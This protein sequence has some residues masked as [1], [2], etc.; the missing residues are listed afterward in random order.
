MG[1]SLYKVDAEF[2]NVFRAARMS[3]RCLLFVSACVAV[4][5]GQGTAFGP[6]EAGA[7]G[8]SLDAVAYNSA[9]KSWEIDV[10]Y[11]LP[12]EDT[13]AV[14]YMPKLS[15]ADFQS[16]FQA[17]MHPCVDTTSVCCLLAFAEH[18]T[19]GTFADTITSTLGACGAD[20]SSQDTAALF[21]AAAYPTVMDNL[22]D[23][24]RNRA[25]S[26][27]VR[28]SPTT[29]QMQVTDR[30][31]SDFF[32]STRTTATGYDLDFFVGVAFFTVLPAPVVSTTTSQIRVNVQYTDSF[33]F[34]SASEQDYSFVDRVTLSIFDNKW[35]SDLFV[36]HHPQAARVGFLLGNGLQQNMRTGLVPA[37]STQFAIAQSQPGPDDPRWVSS[38]GDVLAAQAAVYN[39]SLMEACAVQGDLCANPG[40]AEIPNRYHELWLP[41]GDDAVNRTILDSGAPF[42]LYLRF[43]VSVVDAS[44]A[45]LQTKLFLQSPLSDLAVT[46]LCTELKVAT[47][48]VDVVD[49]HM[50]VGMVGVESEWAPTMGVYEN[51]LVADTAPLVDVNIGSGAR[52]IQNSL[53]TLVLQAEQSMFR[54][55]DRS[56]YLEV[57][58]IVSLHFLDSAV[59]DTVSTMFASGEAWTL[60]KDPASGI[61]QIVLTQELLDLCTAAGLPGDLTCAVRYDVVDHVPVSGYGVH[62]MGTAATHVQT[63]PYSEDATVAWMQ[64]S[65]LGVSEYSDSLA[66][67][68]TALVRDRY[69]I[70]EHYN[71]ALYLNPGFPWTL[72]AGTGQSTLS[73]SDRTIWIIL[74]RL[75]GLS[76]RRR[77]LLQ[78]DSAEEQFYEKIVEL[79]EKPMA[80]R[81][82]PLR[83]YA[84]DPLVQTA[85]A[86]GV[87]RGFGFADVGLSVPVELDAKKLKRRVQGL[88]GESLGVISPT[89]AGAWVVKSRRV[90]GAGGQRRLLAGGAGPTFEYD[91]RVL[92]N[93]TSFDS[94]VSEAHFRE[95]IVNGTLA[96]SGAQGEQYE[97]LRDLISVRFDVL[98]STYPEYADRW[99]RVEKTFENQFAADFGQ[100]TPYPSQY[101]ESPGAESRDEFGVPNDA[102]RVGG[103]WWVWCCV[104]LAA[105]STHMS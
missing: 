101:V 65:F 58:S 90:Q 86:Y 71:K 60:E 10:R 87:E 62:L 82:P 42:S 72:S 2:R 5:S 75:D 63:L 35:V 79:G 92:M 41:L 80:D 4:V 94:E 25:E 104:L 57:E 96:E 30:D 44:G 52:S 39:S 29:V 68:F 93:F 19:I 69:A 73:L 14:L 64:E 9:S 78:V 45:A 105:A 18:Y 48:V 32:A 24:L 36:E 43:I 53:T 67:N 13:I 26:F 55:V 49:L 28:T 66:R 51:L 74:V 40:T 59:Y 15:S 102:G 7:H 70:N 100:S 88:L 98:N 91:I 38:C 27:V 23:G 6:V 34:S 3:M 95:L 85:A 17:S 12:G 56:P 31:L 99:A 22:L 89:A 37:L 8:F 97:L 50:L 33:V 21:D 54:R 11:T 46:R 16:S 76:V 47:G 61:G 81:L 77:V 1:F 83:N 103:G 84:I 20:I